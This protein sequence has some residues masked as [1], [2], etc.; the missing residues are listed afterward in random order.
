MHAK[1]EKP[2]S[3]LWKSYFVACGCLS[4]ICWNFVLNMT[5]YT[6]FKLTQDFAVFITFSFSLGS[7]L[8]FVAAPLVL[9][10]LSH[11]KAC[12]ICLSLTFACFIGLFL[13]INV[14]ESLKVQQVVAT[15]LIFFCGFFGSF[16][17]S[18]SSGLAA[19]ASSAE[20]VLTNF[21]TGVAGVS[22]NVFGFLIERLFPV[23]KDGD[24]ESAF[25]KQMLAYLFVV[26][27][28][29]IVFIIIENLYE[30]THSQ[31][32]DTKSEAEIEAPLE[33]DK[34]EGGTMVAMSS[35]KIIT[36]CIDLYTGIVLHYAIIL[37][38]LVFFLFAAFGR[39][40]ASSAETLFSI[41]LYLFSFNL[42][43]MIG[44]FLSPALLMSSSTKLHVTNFLKY[45]FI[46]YFV[47]IVVAEEPLA[48]LSSGLA[49]CIVFAVLGMVNGYC[50]NCFFGISTSRFERPLEK[51]KAAYFCVF[52]LLTGI[53][54]GN[55]LGVFFA[56]SQPKV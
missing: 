33:S 26:L 44:K 53:T 5:P 3:F 9:G 6:S 52:F 20:I 1:I 37:C 7:L 2:N 54:F 21:G 29:G 16:F 35:T 42:F 15:I 8:S 40:D 28:F 27:V 13:S 47:Y 14:I 12:L 46:A 30:R 48:A 36:R 17:Q 10:R 32:F 24:V 23:P 45:L 11:R 39:L 19:S 31:Y 4:L 51:G 56:P 50:T 34:Y 43:D 49:R 55:L 18:K 25:R 38:C 41:P 22:S